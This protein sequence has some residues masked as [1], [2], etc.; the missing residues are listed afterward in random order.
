MSAIQVSYRNPFYRHGMQ[1]AGPVITTNARPVQV[2]KYTRYYRVQSDN[3]SAR[4]YDF[5]LNGVCFCM[6]AG[7][8]NESQIDACQIAQENLRKFAIVGAA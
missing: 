7:P 6:R 2:G 8:A 5:V 1:S 3:P 4:V